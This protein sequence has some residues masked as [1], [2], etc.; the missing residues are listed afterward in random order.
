MIPEVRVW[1]SK[2]PWPRRTWDRYTGHKGKNRAK[3]HKAPGGGGKL[4]IKK[5]FRK[6]WETQRGGGGNGGGGAPAR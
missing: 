5:L 2:T 4:K 1:V 6:A 3:L